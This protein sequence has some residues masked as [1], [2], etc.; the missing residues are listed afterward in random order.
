MPILALVLF[1]HYLL[2]F[3]REKSTV[4]IFTTFTTIDCKKV[5]EN[6]T[7]YNNTLTEN[8]TINDYNLIIKNPN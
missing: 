3:F 7:I 2:S 5:T 1:Y 8:V 4:I 6:I